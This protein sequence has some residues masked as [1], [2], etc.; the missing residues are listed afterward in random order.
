MSKQKNKVRTRVLKTGGKL[1]LRDCFNLTKAQKHEFMKAAR[2]EEQQKKKDFQV[3]GMM[4]FTA[5]FKIGEAGLSL[6]YVRSLYP[7][8][9]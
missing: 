5:D 7:K 1:I 9:G 4:D 6:R 8:M 3:G 2:E